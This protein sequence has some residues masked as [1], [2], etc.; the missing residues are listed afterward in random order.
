M[1]VFVRLDE[2]ITF[3]GVAL[4]DAEFELEL[5]ALIGM[6]GELMECSVENV[7]YISYEDSEESNA[8]F[9][10]PYFQEFINEMEDDVLTKLI[11]DNF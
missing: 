5:D 3:K 11:R 6:G 10:K 7:T 8:Y 1:Q 9:L 2:T 4:G